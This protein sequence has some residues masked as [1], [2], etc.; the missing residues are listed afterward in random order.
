MGT[1]NMTRLM[2]IRLIA[3]LLT[4]AL[5]APALLA[6]DGAY[7]V[8]L[9]PGRAVDATRASVEALAASY[10]G[11]VE[12]ADP[13]RSDLY[14]IR[15]PASRA[16]SLAADPRVASVT[17]FEP[18]VSATAT[19]VVNWNSGVAYAYDGSGNVKQI[20]SDKFAYDHVGRVVEAQVNGVRRNYEYDQHGNRQKCRQNDGT[21]TAG[22]CQGYAIDPDDNHIVGAA[23]DPDGT[24]AVV[25]HA[26]HQYSYDEL[27]MLTRH[28]A[29]D[30]REFIYTA[31][32]ERLATYAV[33]GKSWLWTLRDGENRVVREFTSQGGAYG[34]ASFAWLKDY[35]WRDGKLLAS[36]Q[37]A[38]GATT[39]YHYHLDHLG[40]P[41][42]VTDRNDNRVGFHD[43]FAYGQEVNGGEH[44]PSAARIKYTGHERDD[45]GS[46]DYMHARYYDGELGRF[47]SPDPATGSPRRPQTWNRYSYALGN[48]M[49]FTDPMGL[50][51]A[52]VEDILRLFD[53]DGC[54]GTCPRFSMEI[55]VHSTAME[56]TENELRIQRAVQ[57]MVQNN[58]ITQMQQ[59]MIEGDD[60]SLAMAYWDVTLMPFAFMDMGSGGGG[61]RRRVSVDD[62]MDD[63]VPPSGFKGSKGY[64]LS[65]APY[66]DVPGPPRNSRGEVSGVQYSGH[67]FDQMQ[68]RG[69]MPS[70]VKN[71]LDTGTPTAG[72][73]GVIKYYDPVNNVSVFY[74]ADTGRVVTVRWGQ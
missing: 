66:Q 42:R 54:L 37:P 27:K 28:Q 68:N 16:R 61:G 30:A 59:A 72:K 69:I 73:N 22:D 13:A 67:A 10:G 15:L 1:G 56:W 74:G 52:W 41:R 31:S 64:E 58:S 33:A 7:V 34:T 36:V 17:P 70:V 3:L 55:D 35:V 4:A 11:S 5:W 20:G 19:E 26:G 49:R 25:G 6:G 21:A 50:W 14:V 48:P 12:G 53:A 63:A 45:L 51:P 32:D 8:T 2:N 57:W 29:G 44:E 18:A 65:N 40:T 62:V 23:Y 60:F 9:D 46:L 39:T 71:T 38:G 24:G 43:Y 47:L